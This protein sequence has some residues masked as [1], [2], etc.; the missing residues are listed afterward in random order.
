MTHE[1]DLEGDR[2]QP[3]ALISSK[4][5]QVIN[6]LTEYFADDRI[7][8]DDFESRLD[9][10]HKTQSLELLDAILV[11][12]AGVVPSKAVVTP[13]V[14][15]GDRRARSLMLGFWGASSRKGAWIPAR[16]NFV[17]AFQGGVELD[18]REAQLPPGT[19]EITVFCAMGGA[20]IIVPPGLRVDFG[21]IGI[22]GG[23]EAELS[24]P[25]DND[26]N[27]PVLRVNGLAVWGGASV[28][29][30][31]AGETGREAKQRRRIERK[32]KRQLSS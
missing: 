7:G 31:R 28:E 23:F 2:P 3:K 8:L 27:A 12:L 18:L 4:R 30:R 14:Y 13:T 29:V 1:S 5:E 26:P 16:H 10:I 15:T 32:A 17:I 11:D 19:T 22:M 20:N 25:L 9:R 21:G 24:A 6:T